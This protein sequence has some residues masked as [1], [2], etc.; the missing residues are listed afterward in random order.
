MPWTTTGNMRCTWRR[1][2][3]TPS[4]LIAY[5]LRD[6]G[7]GTLFE[8]A[9]D[10]V[11]TGDTDGLKALIGQC[12]DLVSARSPRPHCCTLLNYLGANGFENER[13]KTPANAVAIIDFLIAAGSDPNAVCFTYRG[14]PAQNTIGLLT[15]SAHPKAAGLT[16]AMVDALTRGGA[17]L[18]AIYALLVRISNSQPMPDGF[19]PASDSARRALVESAGLGKP[20]ILFRL[21]DAGV[22]VNAQRADGATALH[23]AAF[24][25]VSRLVDQ[26]L[27]HG[28]DPRLDQEKGTVR[29]PTAGE[30]SPLGIPRPP[31]LKPSGISH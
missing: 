20:G 5:S 6:A 16:L 25:G 3:L 12:P 15:S 19:D 26:L 2:A 8:R 22:D 31:R 23:Q 24:E 27:A 29:S 18:D 4:Q 14:G 7:F 21:V 1:P 11:V 28:A 10:A 17:E 30:P 13:Q 9:A